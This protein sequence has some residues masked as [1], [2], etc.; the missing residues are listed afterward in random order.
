MLYWLSI[1]LFTYRSGAVLRGLLWNQFRLAH[2][3]KLIIL[4]LSFELS[5]FSEVCRLDMLTL[6]GAR[7]HERLMSERTL[8]NPW[9]LVRLEMRCEGPCV[10]LLLSFLT[11]T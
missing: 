2:F 5:L 9:L 1:L 4:L 3:S 8:L 7:L 6:I 10:F 11:G